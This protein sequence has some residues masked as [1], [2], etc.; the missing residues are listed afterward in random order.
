MKVECFDWGA[1]YNRMPGAGDTDLH[2]VGT[3][4]LAS[5]STELSLQPG[6][7]GISPEPGVFV[8][9][10]TATT[11][12]VCLDQ[13]DEGRQVEWRGDAGEGIER[14]RIIGAAEASIEVQEAN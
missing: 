1:W 6:D 3:C 10:L 2:V 14:V 12:E 11:P 9:Q 8:L 5:V 13:I 7:P 4:R